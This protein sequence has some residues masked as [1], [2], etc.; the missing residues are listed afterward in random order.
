MS[1]RT[2]TMLCIFLLLESQQ[3]AKTRKPPSEDKD[4]MKI[5]KTLVTLSAQRAADFGRLQAQ[6][7]AEDDE[8]REGEDGK[9]EGGAL[10]EKKTN[11]ETDSKEDEET[12]EQEFEPSKE[13]SSRRAR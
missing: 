6:T 10:T 3:E 7:D 12:E 1:E 11:E 2:A 9:S 13:S 8:L 5:W 4:V